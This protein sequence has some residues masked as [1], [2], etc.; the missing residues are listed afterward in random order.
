M[1]DTPEWHDPFAQDPAAVER[2]RRRAEREARRKARQQSLADKVQSEAGAIAPPVE[3]PPAEPPPAAAP[4]SA[5]DEHELPPPLP[6]RPAYGPQPPR[7][8]L[9]RRIIGALLFL[10]VLGGLAFGVSKVVDRLGGDDPE[11]KPVKQPKTTEITVPEGLDRHQIAAVAED[12]GLKGNYLEATKKP[13]KKSGFDLAKYD[14]EDAPNLEGFLFPDTWNDLP[15]KATV[16]DLVDRQLVDFEQRFKG[17]DLSYAKSKN[18]N[19]YDV[20]IIASIIEK[21]IAVPEERKLAAAVVYNRLAANNPLGMDATIRYYLQNYD[22]QLTES[23]LAEDQPY[24]TRIH[25]GLPPT[26]ISN[27]GLASIEAA[28]DP[29]RSDVFYFV[30][31]P[32]TCNEHTFVETE[33]EFQ[34][35]EAEYQQALQEQGGSPTEC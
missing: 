7:S 5:T 29:A 34:Q 9:V 31:K 8:L 23:E 18:L 13:P 1:T 32:G 21:E 3:A 35:A 26:P 15:K 6:P 11:P 20:L 19:A 25:P 22:E 12:A 16:D 10:A 2:E 14:A 24:N 30:I 17:V 4:P 33:E 28:A 27:P